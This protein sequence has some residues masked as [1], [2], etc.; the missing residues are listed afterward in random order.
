MERERKIAI[1]CSSYFNFHSINIGISPII[2]TVIKSVNQ[3]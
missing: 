1:F 3:L 2:Y